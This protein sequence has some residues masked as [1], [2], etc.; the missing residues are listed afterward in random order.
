MPEN[1]KKSAV[2]TGLE[3]VTFPSNPK[4]GQCQRNVQTTTELHPFH[5]LA[6]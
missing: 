5:M 4:E 1:L 3:N 2:A 6:K